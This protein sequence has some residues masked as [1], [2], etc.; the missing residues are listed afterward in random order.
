MRGRSS[1]RCV[2]SAVGLD[3]LTTAEG[4]ETE[5]QFDILRAAGVDLAQG[6]LF[7]RPAPLS[8]FKLFVEAAGHAAEDAA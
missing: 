4:V 3:M 2:R 7:G 1:R 8:E 6:Y 5:Q